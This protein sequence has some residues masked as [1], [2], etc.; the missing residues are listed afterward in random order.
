MKRAPDDHHLLRRLQIFFG[1]KSWN[2][3]FW[4]DYLWISSLEIQHCTNS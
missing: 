4:N 2:K 1:I 3:Q